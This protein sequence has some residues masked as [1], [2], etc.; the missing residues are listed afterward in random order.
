MPPRDEL[1]RLARALALPERDL[2]ILAEGNVSAL[3]SPGRML[4]KGSGKRMDAMSDADF[5]DLALD[6]VIGLMRQPP[7]GDESVRAAL[8]A[9]TLA[10]PPPST[11]AFMHAALIE[12]GAHFVAHVHPTSLLSILCLPLAEDWAKRRLFPDQIVLCG[13]ASCFIPYVAPGIA[14]AQAVLSGRSEFRLRYG[15]DPKT[16]WLQNHG[17]I[18]VGATSLEVEAACLMS[19]KAARILLAALACGEPARWLNAEEVARI[20]QW[21]DEHARQRA[22]WGK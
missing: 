6:S 12:S 2:C 3:D 16:Y 22:L 14:L 21:P 19:E 7:E 15:E 8:N 10:G 20:Q 18:A 4:V 11:E 5:S 17:L 1:L 9:C 13:P